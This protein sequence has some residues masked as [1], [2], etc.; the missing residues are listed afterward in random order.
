MSKSEKDG[1]ILIVGGGPAG[2]GAALAFDNNKYKNIIV[3]EGR[4]DMNFDVDDSYLV[5][6]NVR[7]QNSI[8]KLFSN[9]EKQP[10]L[11]NLGLRVDKWKILVGPGINVANFESGLVQSTSRAEITHILYNEA[12][13]RPSITVLFGHKAKA[14]D[15]ETKKVVSEAKNGEEEKIFH[16]ACLVIAD[17]YR[18]KMRDQLAEADKTLK[19]QQW[20]WNIK[21]RSLVSQPNPETSLNPYAHYIQNQLYTA[22]YLD[23]KWATGVSIKDD[24]P[25]FLS[26]NDPSE[27]NIDDLQRYLK[28][29]ARPA[30]DL[31]TREDLKKYFSRSI[32]SGAVTKVSKLVVDKWALIIGDAAHSPFPAT[33]EGIN[34][35]LEDCALLQSSLEKNDNIGDCLIDFEKGRLEDVNALSDIAYSTVRP[36]V[37]SRIQMFVRPL[38]KKFGPS[39]E[40]LMFGK[41]SANTHSYSECVKIW[42]DQA[43]FLGGA[44]VPKNESKKNKK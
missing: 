15:L 6:L 21:F 37:A 8:K 31:Y 12:K 2:L 24:S 43:K 38:S 39:K 42:K 16:P 36:T 44:N 9:S 23:G 13:L 35:A 18:S 32:F 33:G 19:V 25:E 10:D 34:S 41:Q 17:G 26:S 7:G 3:L 1:L 28:K 30:A 11:S 22:K 4:N 20:P 14:V 29:M 5:G 27:K 40:D